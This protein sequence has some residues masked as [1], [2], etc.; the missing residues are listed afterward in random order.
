[1]DE[2]GNDEEGLHYQIEQL[3]RE[4]DELRK[5]IE[6]LCMQQAGS[7]YLAVATRMHFQR[8]AGL[9]QEIETLKKKL[10]GCMREK[11]NLEEEL[12]EAYHIKSQLADLHAAETLKN[13]EAEK[14]VKFFQGCV[15]AAFSERDSSLMEAEKAKEREEA[16]SQ[17][18]VHLEKKVQELESAYLDEKKLSAFLQMELDELREQTEVC[19][20]VV[21]KFYE[22]REGEYM[23]SADIMLQ[24]KCAFLL[25]D[26]PSNWIFNSDGETSTSNYIATLEEE[27]EALKNSV[28]KL[29]KNLQMGLK[30]EQHLKGRLQSL[31]KRQIILDS[32]LRKE[33]SALRRY[34]TQHRLEIMKELE[35]ASSWMDAVAVEVQKKLNEVQIDPE[36]SAMTPHGERHCDDTECR[37]VHVMHDVN[38]SSTDKKSDIPS[39]IVDQSYVPDALA[40][41]S[42]Q[43]SNAPSSSGDQSSTNVPDALA[44]A[45]QE[46]V[47][48]LLLLSQQEERHLL[49][50]DLCKALQNKLDELQRN[51]SQ[52][53]NEKVKALMELAELRRDYQLLKE[54]NLYSSKHNS[55]VDDPEKS[56]A[57]LEQEGKLKNILKRTYLK[58]WMV[59]DHTQHGA[60][61]SKSTGQSNPTNAKH[62]TSMDFARLKIENAALREII[63]NLEHLTSSVHRLHILLLKVQDEVSS[64]G[65]IENKIEALSNIVI[66]A[67]HVKTA[68]GGSLPVSWSGDETDAITYSCLNESSDPS[69]ASN[70]EKLDA[71]PAAGREMVELL[72]LAT[73]LQ[74][75][76]LRGKCIDLQN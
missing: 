45:L 10:A 18:F 4:R 69:E 46:K 8:T 75:E 55:C 68:L 37:D 22:I 26:P 14:Q 48:A 61:P 2:R 70:T 43:E 63:A 74:K 13:K 52:V 60:N 12:S 66:D 16:M 59:H 62:Y 11:Q 71:V 3:K 53:T 73:E 19:E 56:S 31:E 44:Q 49:E 6:Q 51:L 65:T 35:E 38:S 34:H 28:N 23:L 72:I 30:I 41:N 67:N 24:D 17:K 40:Q 57:L 33:L 21:N 76:I 5:D 32:S 39:S 42:Q 20:K 25:N 7:S 29:Q 64:D 9:E 1:M 58:R 47:S 15:A 27:K 54:N 50:R 36:S